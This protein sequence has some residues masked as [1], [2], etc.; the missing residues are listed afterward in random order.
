MTNFYENELKFLVLL[1]KIMGFNSL[2][3]DQN[4]QAR[5]I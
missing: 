3:A 5:K 2:S 4:I 1:I